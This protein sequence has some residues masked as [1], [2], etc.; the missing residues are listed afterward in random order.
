MRNPNHFEG[1]RSQMIQKILFQKRDTRGRPLPNYSE[2]WFP[3]PEKCNGLSIFTPL[4]SEIFD[5]VFEFQRLVKTDPTSDDF[6]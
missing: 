6:E 3:T 2:L 4:Q 5:Q 1:K